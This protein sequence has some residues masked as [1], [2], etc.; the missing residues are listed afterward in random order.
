MRSQGGF[1]I[2][3]ECGQHADPAAPDVAYRAICNTL[4]HLGL[5]D[6]ADPKPHD[7]V[8]FLKLTQVVDRYHPQDHFSQTWSSFDPV[9]AGQ[10]IGIRHD[11]TLVHA[12]EDGYIV[13][14]NANATPGNEWFYLAQRSARDIHASPH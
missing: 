5:V 14:P 12:M 8:E 4:A 7:A 11:G 2:T 6:E 9:S 3:L 1:A 10:T 13:F